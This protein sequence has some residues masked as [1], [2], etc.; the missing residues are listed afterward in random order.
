MS[1][2]K[3]DLKLFPIRE[4]TKIQQIRKHEVNLHVKRSKFHLLV[5]LNMPKVNLIHIG[6][7]QFNMIRILVLNL[8]AQERSFPLH[9]H[10]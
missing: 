3:Y 7:Q 5:Q 10:G 2:F 8:K 6:L 1:V 4:L 9:I